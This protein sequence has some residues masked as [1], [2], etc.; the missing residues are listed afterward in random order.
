MH[1]SAV[2][3]APLFQKES[4]VR[5]LESGPGQLPQ[6]LKRPTSCPAVLRRPRIKGDC[7]IALLY[8]PSMAVNSRCELEPRRENHAWCVKITPVEEDST[9]SPR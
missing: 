7:L 4:S 6:S 2:K 9:A 5:R 8:S 1:F 3:S